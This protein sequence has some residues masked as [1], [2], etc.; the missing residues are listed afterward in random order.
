MQINFKAKTNKDYCR[1]N[2]A[3]FTLR[4]GGTVTVDRDE[5]EYTIEDGVLSMTWNNVY[6]WKIDGVNIVDE[7]PYLNDHFADFFSTA[8]SVELELE[9]DADEDYS[10]TDVSFWV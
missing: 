3:T 10:V 4:D 9:D 5:T 2:T 7:S 6:L 8:T 1:I